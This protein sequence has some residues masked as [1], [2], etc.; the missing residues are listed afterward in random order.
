MKPLHF[1]MNPLDRSQGSSYTNRTTG[2]EKSGAA[3][4]N[5][6]GMATK[7]KIVALLDVNYP[8]VP[9]WESD[10]TFKEALE[11]TLG[12][13]ISQQAPNQESTHSTNVAKDYM[14]GG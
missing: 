8:P 10:K 5:S 6:E 14:V 7:D 2:S 9:K 3:K 12:R 4:L 1:R 13:N 11:Q